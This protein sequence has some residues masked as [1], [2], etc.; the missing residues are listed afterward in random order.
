VRRGAGAQGATVVA[1]IPVLPRQGYIPDGTTREVG[2]ANPDV[3]LEQ[4]GGCTGV[5]DELQMDGLDHVGLNRFGQDNATRNNVNHLLQDRAAD[6]LEGG[7]RR[8]G[9]HCHISIRVEHLEI[10]VSV[11]THGG[12]N[13]KG[14]GGGA[15]QILGDDL[16]VEVSHGRVKA[17]LAVDAG[18]GGHDLGKLGAMDSADGV[19]TS[20]H[21][22][23]LCLVEAHAV[24]LLAESDH[25]VLWLRHTEGPR[26]RRVYASQ[27][28][29]N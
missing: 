24:K 17:D 1:A 10:G 9:V 3:S 15:I 21:L 26:R 18:S 4:E 25:R 8:Q 12:A 5:Q 2:G 29:G 20:R 13:D 7:G 22:D 14:V 19:A 16:V 27:A 11:Y 23:H 6:V 28:Q